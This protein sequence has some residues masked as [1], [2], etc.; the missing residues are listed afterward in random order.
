MIILMI[1]D[2]EGVDNIE[3]IV[4]INGVDCVFLGR[5]DLSLS[6]GCVGQKDDPDLNAAIDKVVRVTLDA[7]LGLM[8]ATDERE[9]PHWIRRGARFFRFKWFHFLDESGPN[10][11]WRY[12]IICAINREILMSLGFSTKLEGW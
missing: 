10:R 5:G 1:E 9:G 2:M 6:M 8:V 4:E 3:S 7:G 11:W 12:E